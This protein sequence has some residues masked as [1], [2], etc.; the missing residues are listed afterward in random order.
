MPKLDRG[1]GISDLR[2]QDL[3]S[4]LC[5][6]R[7]TSAKSAEHLFLTCDLSSTARYSTFRWLGYNL[8]CL[9]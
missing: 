4:N 2:Y 9:R 3:R 5:I 7:G 6:L 8:S 1:L